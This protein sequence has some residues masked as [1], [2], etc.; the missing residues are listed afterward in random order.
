MTERV[1]G[2]VLADGANEFGGLIALIQ[3]G[4]RWPRLRREMV[5]AG[6]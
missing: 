5:G 1:K 2:L 6:H 4:R 3:A